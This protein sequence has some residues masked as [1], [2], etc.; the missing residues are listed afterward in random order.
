MQWS[1]DEVKALFSSANVTT[2]TDE[3]TPGSDTNDPVPTSSSETDDTSTV[4]TL[5][6]SNTGLIASCAVAGCVVL[7]AICGAAWFINKRRRSKRTQ[8]PSS[9]PWPDNNPDA[10]KGQS[11]I[12]ELPL[13]GSAVEVYVPPAEMAGRDARH[14][15]AELGAPT[16]AGDGPLR[17]PA[18]RAE[19][20]G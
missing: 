18:Y 12:Q 14:L 9:S 7:L 3:P 13:Q 10:S 5:K 17:T 4:P 8:E 15:Y 11:Q 19:L 6:K 1:S 2:G 16:G 20:S